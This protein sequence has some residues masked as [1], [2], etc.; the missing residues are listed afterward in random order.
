VN[1]SATSLPTP[2]KGRT[3]GVYGFAAWFCFGALFE[4][5]KLAKNGGGGEVFCGFIWVE[6]WGIIASVHLAAALYY[7]T[8]AFGL[9]GVRPYAF[10]M[11][12]LINVAGLLCESFWWLWGR[13]VVLAHGREPVGLLYSAIGA[14]WYALAFGW[15]WLRR[16]NFRG[17][18][19]RSLDSGATEDDGN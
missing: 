10:W 18:P 15:C 19:R 5:Y 16:A 3:F 14:T 7:L 1:I 12:F 6:E 17:Q 4:V 9:L 11:F 8:C 13:D 2:A